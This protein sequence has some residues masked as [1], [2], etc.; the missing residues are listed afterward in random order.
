MNYEFK[1]NILNKDYIDVLVIALARQG[2]APYITEDN[3]VCITI[4]DVE[5]TKLKEK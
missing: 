3:E 4:D 5:I 2:Y 1:I